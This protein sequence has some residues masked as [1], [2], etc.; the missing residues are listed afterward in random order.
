MVRVEGKRYRNDPYN[1]TVLPP[2]PMIR[3][4]MATAA[5][6]AGV[7]VANQAP[8]P[9]KFNAVTTTMTPKP[10]PMAPSPVEQAATPLAPSKKTPVTHYA[11][12]DFK[13]ESV[14]FVAPFKVAAGDQVVVEGDRGEHIG[15][16][17]GIT[18]DVPTYAVPRKVLRRATEQDLQQLREKRDKEDTATATC[19]KALKS[20]GLRAS[21]VDTEY[22]MDLNKLTIFVR[23]P[24]RNAFV[25]FR[26]LQRGLF[27]D[28]RCRIWLAYMDEVEEARAA[29]RTQ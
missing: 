8:T 19:H 4:A 5:R 12:V 6:Q 23:R 21:V 28:F 20:L 26:K 24:S 16:V 10:V 17:S 13:H 2:S 3:E 9:S 14:T 25:D 7:A 29:P 27:R 11:F 1:G 15:T 22:Q 18:T